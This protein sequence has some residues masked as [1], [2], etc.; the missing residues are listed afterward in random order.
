MT[1][2]L[3][4]IRARKTFPGIFPIASIFLVC[5][6][7][8]LIYK[9]FYQLAFS[10][11]DIH[12]PRTLFLDRDGVINHEKHNDYVHHWSEFVFYDGVPEAMRIFAEK[13]TYIFVVTNQRGVGKG[14]TK[15]EDLLEI[16]HNMKAAVTAAGGRIDQVY[17]CPDIDNGSTNRKPQTGMALQAKRDYPGVD[18]ANSVMVGNTLSDMEFGRNI[19]ATTVFLPT[20]LPHVNASDSRIDRVYPSLA[21]FAAD[22]CN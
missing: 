5:C 3:F 4:W 14:L 2:K 6:P 17:F 20:T 13:F 16:H 7:T 11:T 10:L 19:G 9:K 8:Y 22:L 1:I 21:D 12:V 18:F 15:L